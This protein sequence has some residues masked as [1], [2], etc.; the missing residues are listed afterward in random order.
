MSKSLPVVDPAELARAPVAF[1]ARLAEAGLELRAAAVETLQINVGKLCNQACR[2][3]HVDAGPKR[4]EVM[5]R[6]TADLC[7]D[8]VRRF[9]IRVVDVTGGAPE[10][11]PSFRH[12]VAEARLTGA[13]ETPP[14]AVGG[15]G[16]GTFTLTQKGLQFQNILREGFS[17]IYIAAERTK[18]L[19]VGAGGAA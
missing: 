19:A 5:T 12:I 9:G 10:L 1:D 16:T 8:A 7:L 4:T 18:G 17:R 6:E 15:T 13:Q 2:H 14:L 3:C 11:C